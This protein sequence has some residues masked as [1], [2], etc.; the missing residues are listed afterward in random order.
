M[1]EQPGE[2]AGGLDPDPGVAGGQRREPQRST[3]GP[4]PAACE[5]TSERCSWA[6]ISAGMCRVASAPKPVETPYTGS[7]DA[8]SS[9]MTSRARAIAASASS[10]RWTGAPS[11]ATARSS[12]N[13]TGP[14]PT[15]TAGPVAGLCR[16]F[17]TAILTRSDRADQTVPA[18]H[19]LR[20]ETPEVT[21]A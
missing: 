15:P 21:R 3:S 2:Q 7:S 18:D 16:W 9:S 6:R 10:V 20:S 17:M 13:E 4:E 8:A 1:L 11:R 5:R 14:T 12:V 19:S